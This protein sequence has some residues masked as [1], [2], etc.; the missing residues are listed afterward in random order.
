MGAKPAFISEEDIIN[1]YSDADSSANPEFIAGTEYPLGL[2]INESI[3]SWSFG[4]YRDLIFIRYNV[5]NSSG[6]TLKDCFLAPAL[7]PDLGQKTGDA[8]SDINSVIDNSDSII[9]RRSLGADPVYSAFA[10]SPERLDMGY[11]YKLSLLYG[12]EYGMIGSALRD[13]PAV[14]S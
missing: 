14:A 5:T 13:T 4:R 7:D 1:S 3:Y 9:V 6:D 2:R 12:K 8:S 10:D 11:Q